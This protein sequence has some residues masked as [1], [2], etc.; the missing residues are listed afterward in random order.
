MRNV[1]WV[2]SVEGRRIR[3]GRREGEAWKMTLGMGRELKGI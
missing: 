3:N 2:S 1:V